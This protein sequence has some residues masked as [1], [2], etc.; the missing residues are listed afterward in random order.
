MLSNYML[1]V[2]TFKTNLVIWERETMNILGDVFKIKPEYQVK[3]V[4][5]RPTTAFDPASKFPSPKFS[6]QFKT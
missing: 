3:E 1:S 2:N 5:N 4:K 6:P